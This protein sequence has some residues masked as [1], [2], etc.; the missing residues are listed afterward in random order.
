MKIKET[1]AAEFD[2][3]SDNYTEVM[4]QV[5]AALPPTPVKSR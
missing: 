1:L 4:I 5:C 3:F 2:Q